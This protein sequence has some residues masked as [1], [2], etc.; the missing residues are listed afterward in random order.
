MHDR[1]ETDVNLSKI[2][3]EQIKI[4]IFRW[5]CQSKTFSAFLCRNIWHIHVCLIGSSTTDDSNTLAMAF[6]MMLVTTNIL[7]WMLGAM[8]HA[9]RIGLVIMTDCYIFRKLNKIIS[10][11]KNFIYH[12]QTNCSSILTMPDRRAASRL[13]IH[14]LCRN[15][16]QKNWSKVSHQ[17]SFNIL[18]L[19]STQKF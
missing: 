4:G 11:H 15:R 18:Q 16:K 5:K 17:D 2:S 10:T 3:F 1:T 13:C 7:S 19:Q 8:I 6:G 9:D 12:P 14:V